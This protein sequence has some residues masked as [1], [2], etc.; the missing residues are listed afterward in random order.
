MHMMMLGQFCDL[1][2]SLEKT[3]RASAV[4]SYI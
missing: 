4:C 3:V 2:L 1:G